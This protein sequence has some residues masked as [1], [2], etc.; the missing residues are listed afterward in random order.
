MIQSFTG[1][2]SHLIAE[3]GVNHQ[4]DVSRAANMISAAAA[5]GCSSVKLQYYRS[6]RIASNHASAYWDTQ[7]ESSTSQ[8]ELFARY[9]MLTVPEIETLCNHAHDNGVDFGLSVFDVELVSE[10]SHIIDYF[11]VASGDITFAPLIKAIS[12]TGKPTVFSTGASKLDEV[13]RAVSLFYEHGTTDPIILQ[14][15]L[16][17]PTDM[18][19]AN[20]GSLTS[21]RLALPKL[22][23]GVSDHIANPDLLRFALARALGAQVFEKHFSDTPGGVGN[24]HYHSFGLKE[25]RA[26]VDILSS[27]D[28]LLGS[29]NFMLDSEKAARVGARRSIVYSKDCKK[30]TRL[31]GED[32][33]FLRPAIGMSPFELDQLEGRILMEDVYKGDPVQHNSFTGD[34]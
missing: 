20:I 29:G 3:I 22:A 34:T 13:L 19:D 2:H 10:V 18:A 15:T 4:G 8:S 31:S 30:G 11:K 6:H 7:H 23:V 17:Y 27:T 9:R 12:K 25:M 1:R 16:N 24:D 26:L 5:A 28:G 32:F 21:L 33:D 14:C